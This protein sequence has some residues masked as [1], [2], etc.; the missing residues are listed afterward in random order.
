MMQLKYPKYK[1]FSNSTPTQKEI[2]PIQDLQNALLDSKTIIQMKER[3]LIWRYQLK[4]LPKKSG[5]E[6]CIL[7]N[8]PETSEHIFLTCPANK[9]DAHSLLRNYNRD[10]I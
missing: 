3:D 5:N 10:L 4:A 1:E 8:Q 6:T 7:C 9:E 2:M